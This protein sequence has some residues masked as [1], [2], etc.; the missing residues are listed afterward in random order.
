MG[1]KVRLEGVRVSFADGL[2]HAKAFDD[3]QQPKYGADFLLVEG[4]KVIRSPTVRRLR[5]RWAPF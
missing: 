5:R 3:G 4:S 1:I 2:F